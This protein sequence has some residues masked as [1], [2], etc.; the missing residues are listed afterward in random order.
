[1]LYLVP[2]GAVCLYSPT[3]VVA[4]PLFR[5]SLQER[6]PRRPFLHTYTADRQHPYRHCKHC[7]DV[8]AH[9]SPTLPHGRLPPR[10]NTV[11]LNETNFAVSWPYLISCKKEGSCFCRISLYSMTQLTYTHYVS[12][13]EPFWL[14]RNQWPQYHQVS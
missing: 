10:T 12:R 9:D 6:S 5:Q 8:A 14:R 7:H 13:R 3:S 2:E 11:N 4:R 1:M